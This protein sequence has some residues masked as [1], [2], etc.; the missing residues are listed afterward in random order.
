VIAMP[1]RADAVLADVLE[2]HA[3]ERPDQ[4]FAPLNTAYRGTLLASALNVT[5]AR[6]L[7]VHAEL[8]GRSRGA[9]DGA[10]WSYGI[11][12]GRQAADI[13]AGSR[14]SMCIDD[15]VEKAQGHA[16]RPAW[17]SMAPRASC[18]ATI[19]FSNGCGPPT[20]KRCSAITAS[21]STLGRMSGRG[22][23][24]SQDVMGLRSH[25]A[26]TRSLRLTFSSGFRRI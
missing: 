24:L 10:L 26:G 17:S 7:I 11:A 19:R 15:G 5:K 4:P 13:E 6:V 1:T 8:V 3:S 22:R 25:P 18:S 21:M 12:R 23:P 14:V 9:L 2:R 16:E 20:R